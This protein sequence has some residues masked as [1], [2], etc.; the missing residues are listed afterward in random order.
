M[1]GLGSRGLG[2]RCLGFR[3]LAFRGLGFGDCFFE[4]HAL[5]LSIEI[6]VT[7]DE[8]LGLLVY[9]SNRVRISGWPLPEAQ[10]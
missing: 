3:V 10:Q 8:D 1:Q 4:G 7:C 6:H 9:H 2:S 5:N